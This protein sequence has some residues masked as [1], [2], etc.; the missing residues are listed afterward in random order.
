MATE[1]DDALANFLERIASSAQNGAL[2]FDHVAQASLRRAATRIRDIKVREPIVPWR[3]LYIPD[4]DRDA[5]AWFE[6]KL[7]SL[8]SDGIRCAAEYVL[9]RE[10]ELRCLVLWDVHP[11]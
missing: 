1:E 6:E 9:E 10:R 7:R 8:A 3:D 4:G 2:A 11:D 5:R